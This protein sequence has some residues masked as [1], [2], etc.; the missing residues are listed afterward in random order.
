[1]GWRKKIKNEKIKITYIKKIKTQLFWYIK[2]FICKL[3]QRIKKSKLIA[4]MTTQNQQN[5][6]KQ[7]KK[8]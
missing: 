7:K 5:A 1:M 2:H 6:L 8:N 4:N 3:I